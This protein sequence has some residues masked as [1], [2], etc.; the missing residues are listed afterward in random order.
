MF[1]TSYYLTPLNF[2]SVI[3]MLQE[4]CRQYYL[5]KSSKHYIDKNLVYKSWFIEYSPY[6]PKKIKT[7]EVMMFIHKHPFR[8]TYE[9]FKKGEKIPI[10]QQVEIDLYRDSIPLIEISIGLNR[11]I[12]LRQFNKVTFYPFGIFKIDE[13]GD[14]I[15]P[16]PSNS[17]HYLFLPNRFHKIYNY[18]MEFLARVKMEQKMRETLMKEMNKWDSDEEPPII[19]YQEESDQVINLDD[20]LGKES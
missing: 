17:I 2:E 15:D 8:D 18:D 6:T 11:T 19:E 12:T 20:I 4:R 16:S 9:R 3:S 5:L 7:N 1:D 10:L 13:Y 14:Q